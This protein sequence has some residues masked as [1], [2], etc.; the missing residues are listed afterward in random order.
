[1]LKIKKPDFIS[2]EDKIWIDGAVEEFLAENHPLHFNPHNRS[3]HTIVDNYFDLNPLSNLTRGEVAFW[4]IKIA[5]DNWGL[6][7]PQKINDILD[8]D[9]PIQIS[10]SYEYAKQMKQAAGAREI[11]DNMPAGTPEFTVKIPFGDEVNQPKN[12]YYFV[13]SQLAEMEFVIELSDV[14]RSTKRYGHHKNENYRAVVWCNEYF[15]ICVKF[16]EIKGAE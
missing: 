13:D 14:T 7:F 1:M 4:V 8:N 11:Y 16:F 10:Q 5:R 15:Q 3:T 2:N 9:K 6:E 12:D